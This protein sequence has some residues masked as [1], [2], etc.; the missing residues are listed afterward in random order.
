M[1]YPLQ[2][3]NLLNKEF[4]EHI[5]YKEYHSKEL[6]KCMMCIW[7][8]KS[9][10]NIEKSIYNTI[11]PD[12]CIDLIIDF[13][14]KQIIFSACSK[15]TEF[16]ELNGRVDFL[17]V[18][19]KPGA[20]YHIYE[21][22]SSMVMDNMLI[23]H[24]IETNSNLNTI[25]QS[26]NRRQQIEILSDYLNKKTKNYHPNY[27]E[28][29]VDILYE[30]LQDRAMDNILHDLSYSQRH[31]NRLFYKNFGVN[32]K[33]LLNIL[34]LHKSLNILFENKEDN[35]CQLAI[36]CG[37]YDQSHLIKNIKRYC[38]ISPKELINKY[39]T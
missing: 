12:G 39:T 4:K 20:F 34:R 17:G 29:I 6:E 33:T 35:L 37:F 32:P 24:D 21:I 25:F 27:F 15:A 13:T 26:S 23:Y 5:E 1:Y 28:E 19:F 22:D 3:P 8:M 31:L 16:F 11:L 10:H 18:R 14:H 9:K 30:N 38:G 2:I 36:E 7:S